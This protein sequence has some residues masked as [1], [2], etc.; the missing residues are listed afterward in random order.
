MPVEVKIEDLV[1]LGFV[2]QDEI[3]GSR[4]K[5]V[6]RLKKAGVIVSYR[7]STGK[8]MIASRPNGDCRFLDERTRLCT[9]YDNR[10][11]MCRDFPTAVGNRLGHCPYMKQ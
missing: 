1:R 8:F 2:T 7:E 11:Q 5:L 4:G 6:S 3:H 9:V 10:P